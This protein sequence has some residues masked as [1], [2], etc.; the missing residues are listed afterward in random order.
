MVIFICGLGL[1]VSNGCL[2]WSGLCLVGAGFCMG[3]LWLGMGLVFV[4][5]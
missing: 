1:G 2:F 4:V 5:T 3:D